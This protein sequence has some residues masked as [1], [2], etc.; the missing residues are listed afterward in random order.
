LSVRQGNADEVLLSQGRK[1]V[2]SCAET[3][4]VPRFFKVQDIEKGY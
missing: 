4:S 1:G 2:E 3:A